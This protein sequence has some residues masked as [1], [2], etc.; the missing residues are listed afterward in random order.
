MRFLFVSFVFL[1]SFNVVAQDL[2]DRRVAYKPVVL[3]TFITENIVSKQMAE[4][5]QRL[6]LQP[7]AISFEAFLMSQPQPGKFEL[8]YDALS[9]WPSEA[10]GALPNV[11]YS[12]FV[13]Y[14]EEPVIGVYVSEKAA[15]MLQQ[16]DMTKPVT[17]YAI[18][19]YN[20]AKGPRVVIVAAEQP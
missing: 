4:K 15:E 9:L 13:G 8:V 2:V 19:I 3:N 10:E 12:A 11:N 6:M 7:A 17:F 16:V 5:K 18:H 1:F 14:R 20:Y